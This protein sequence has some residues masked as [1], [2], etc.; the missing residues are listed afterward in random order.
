MHRLPLLLGI[1]RIPITHSLHTRI[2]V[3]CL[4][5]ERVG[6]EFS[7]SLTPSTTA[8]SSIMVNPRYPGEAPPLPPKESIDA[9]GI[10]TQF[11]H[12][13]R[14]RRLNDL[15]ERSQRRPDAASPFPPTS[16]ISLP[17][18][19]QAPRPPTD[20][21]ST[22]PTYSS[23]RN[24][25]KIATPP[26]DPASVRFHSQ[27]R[28]HSRRPLN[29]ENPGLLDEALQVV[30][31]DLIYGEAEDECDLLKAQAVSMPGNK[32]PEWGYQDCVIRAL[33]RYAS[34]YSPVSSPLPDP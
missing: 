29:Y 6:R 3:A 33:L 23:L 1:H 34:H 2:Y 24:H 5:R 31:L 12:L 13:L 22:P 7:L 17:P 16:T 14:T 25:P 10:T 30:P 8:A 28:S 19:R 18:S 27:L 32:K 15:A 9:N 20:H 21:P 4:R 11:E 26:Q